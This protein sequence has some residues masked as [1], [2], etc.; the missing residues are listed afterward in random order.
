[1]T[2]QEISNTNTESGNL[3]ERA[4]QSIL[5]AYAWVAGPAMTDQERIRQELVK[6]QRLEVELHGTSIVG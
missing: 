3:L 6:S 4:A 2:E 1:M 5:I